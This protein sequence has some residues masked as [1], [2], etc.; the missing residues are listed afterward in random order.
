MLGIRPA[1]YMARI[2]QDG[3]LET[4][5][6]AEE[7]SL[8]F[9]GVSDRQQCAFQAAVGAGRYAPETIKKAQI[10]LR[11]E[12]VR[13]QPVSLYLKPGSLGRPLQS[14]GNGAVSGDLWVV[15]ADQGDVQDGVWRALFHGY[16]PL[17]C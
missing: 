8:L 3:M 17:A 12:A 6:G 2:F 7:R 11:C 10:G 16:F 14:R 1:Q 4:A 9:A 15:I 5:T 13:G